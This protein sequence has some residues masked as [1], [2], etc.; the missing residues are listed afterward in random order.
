MIFKFL[1]FEDLFSQHKQIYIGKY[2]Y[3]FYLTCYS[4]IQ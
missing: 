2:T 4:F 1:D 3:Y